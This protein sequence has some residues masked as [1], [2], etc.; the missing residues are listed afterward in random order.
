MLNEWTWHS[1]EQ[2]VEIEFLEGARMRKKSGFVLRYRVLAIL[3][4]WIDGIGR[5]R[6]EHVFGTSV[7]SS[8][9]GSNVNEIIDRA[10]LAFGLSCEGEC[11]E[12]AW[13][14]IKAMRWILC[15]DFFSI[16]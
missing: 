8:S 16:E 10:A 7:T 13:K 11:V 2:G 12:S 15:M 5:A 9:T 1:E 14:V 6:V 4:R 3:N